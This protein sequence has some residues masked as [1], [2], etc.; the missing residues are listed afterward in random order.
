MILVQ[1]TVSQMNGEIHIDQ[2]NGIKFTIKYN[3]E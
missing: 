3:L 1:L 2:R